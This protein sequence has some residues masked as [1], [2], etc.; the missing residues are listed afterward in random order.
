MASDPS[1]LR[2][3]LANNSDAAF[4]V[5]LRNALASYFISQGPAT[6]ERTKKML[7]ESQ[8]FVVEREGHSVGAFSFYDVQGGQAE[9]GRFMVLPEEQG[10]GIGEWVLAGAIW[11]AKGFGIR[12]LILTVRKDNDTAISLYAAHSFVPFREEE[13]YIIMRRV[14]WPSP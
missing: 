5:G 14:L 13:G 3:R 2:L 6:E 4:L 1:G 11:R 7:A 9:F 10:K 8:T 12:Q